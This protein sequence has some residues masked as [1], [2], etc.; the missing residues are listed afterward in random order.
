MLR[1]N[2]MND[3]PTAAR[4]ALEAAR[5]G[6]T[7]FTALSG[8][9]C[10]DAVGLCQGRGAGRG[11]NEND[12]RVSGAHDILGVPDGASIGFFHNGILIHEM[13]AVGNGNACGNKNACIGYGQPIGWEMLDLCIGWNGD[14][15][16]PR[17]LVVRYHR[18]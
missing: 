17:N 11:V 13:I 5:G 1:P 7:Y 9:M 2:T 8:E 14:A 16:G 15:F 12:V 4:I 6:G 10:W 3:G 18:I